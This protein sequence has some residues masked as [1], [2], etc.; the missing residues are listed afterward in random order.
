MFTV[1]A[2]LPFLP[3]IEDAMIRQL[4]N[5]DFA[6]REAAT[7]LL[8]RILQDTDGVRNYWALLRVK[9]TAG[10]DLEAASRIKRLY[11]D[12]K[13]KYVLEH[14][15]FVIIIKSDKVIENIDR[16]LWKDFFPGKIQ[17]IRVTRDQINYAL[18]CSTNPWT[19]QQL[20]QVKNH[21]DFKE[22]ILVTDSFP[23]G[24]IIDS[25]FR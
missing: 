8:E 23:L 2:M 21:K 20:S 19:V 3:L 5:D 14:Q 22:F 24:E 9:N 12:H 16:R 10:M 6:K 18:G 17:A 1:A 7:R 25:K 15:F 13:S 4:G 11:L